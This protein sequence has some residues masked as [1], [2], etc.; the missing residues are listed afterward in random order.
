MDFTSDEMFRSVSFRYFSTVL[1]KMPQP[2]KAKASKAAAKT[3][4][5]KAPVVENK[6]EPELDLETAL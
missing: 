1:N 3:A 5:L 4:T 2:P 6:D